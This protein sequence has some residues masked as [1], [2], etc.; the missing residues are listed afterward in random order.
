MKTVII[1]S[2]MALV[3]FSLGVLGL[4]AAV[5]A[6]SPRHQRGKWPHLTIPLLSQNTW[7]ASEAEALTLG[8]HL[9]TI[10]DAAE[11]AWV[12]ATFGGGGAGSSLIG[13]TDRGHEGVFTWASGDTSTF[14]N[15]TSGEPN[16]QGGESFTHMW[17]TGGWND[18]ADS[19]W[20]AWY[21]LHGV[22]EIAPFTPPPMLSIRVSPVELCWDTVTNNWYQLQ[23]CSTLTTNVWVPLSTNLGGGRWCEVLYHRRSS[24]W[25]SPEVLSAFGHEFTGTMTNLAP[26]TY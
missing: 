19:T 12:L 9:V 15:W 14:R 20:Q 25:Q 23:Y 18:L 7:T 22:V 2:V 11:D 17:S 21:P 13:L 3:T 5:I 16:N 6:V 10:N 24:F 8:G 4:Q 1:G 26:N